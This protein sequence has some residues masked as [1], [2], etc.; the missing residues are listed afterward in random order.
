MMIVLVYFSHANSYM[1]EEMGI[2][3]QQQDSGPPSSHLLFFATIPLGFETFSLLFLFNHILS[4][5]SVSF[6][7]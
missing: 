4:C 5:V 7:L 6:S 2:G 3:K 1:S